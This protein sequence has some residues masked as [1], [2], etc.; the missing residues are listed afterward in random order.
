MLLPHPSTVFLKLHRSNLFS[1][2]QIATIK[3]QIFFVNVSEYRSYNT[4]VYYII[5]MKEMRFLGMKSIF[6]GN[7]IVV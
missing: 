3:I 6:S 5:I 2:K 7:Q 4:I 1:L